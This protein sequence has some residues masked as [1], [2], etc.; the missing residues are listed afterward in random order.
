MTWGAGG[1]VKTRVSSLGPDPPGALWACRPG[2]LR[3]GW[4]LGAETVRGRG[5]GGHAWLGLQRWGN[6]PPP[7]PGLTV[8]GPHLFAFGRW[9][10]EAVVG[11]V[12]REDTQLA[13]DDPPGLPKLHLA[14]GGQEGPE[15]AGGEHRA[16]QG[17]SRPVAEAGQG[18]AGD[19]GRGK[20]QSSGV[21]R[22]TTGGWSPLHACGRSP[23]SPEPAHK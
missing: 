21:P 1:A 18:Q 5:R 2:A 6:H 17:C 13:G 10:V 11:Q 16:W 8:G 3:G 20:S 15:V 19:L 9:W 14:L 7:P 22:T 12:A 4:G 23:W